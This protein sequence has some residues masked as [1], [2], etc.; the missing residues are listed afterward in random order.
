MEEP[1]QIQGCLSTLEEQLGSAEGMFRFLSS[2][3]K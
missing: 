3:E 1:V 2:I